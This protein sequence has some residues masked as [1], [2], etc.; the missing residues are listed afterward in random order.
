MTNPSV[1]KFANMPAGE[2]HNS[3]KKHFFD[4]LSGYEDSGIEFFISKPNAP[5]FMVEVTD[6]VAGM[7][8]LK[9]IQAIYPFK[10]GIMRKSFTGS[11][12]VNI[13]PE[14]ATVPKE[15]TP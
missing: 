8:M 4:L 11:H 6:S 12:F 10:I 7:D 15:D 2:T 3:L 5:E 13:Y 9:A 14:W 1:D